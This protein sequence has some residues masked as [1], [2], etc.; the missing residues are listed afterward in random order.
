MLE[1][2]GKI[3]KYIIWESRRCCNW[4]EGIKSDI[5]RSHLR[6]Y[7]NMKDCVALKST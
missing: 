5:H 1:V 7:Y 3:P 4:R 2:I 6:F